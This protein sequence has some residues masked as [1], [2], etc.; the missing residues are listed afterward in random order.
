MKSRKIFLSILAMMLISVGSL[1]AQRQLLDRVVA[2]V[3]DEVINQSELDNVLHPIYEQ[4]EQEYEGEDLILRFNEVRRKLLN[5]LIEDRLVFQEAEEQKI[6]VEASELDARV[7]E[8]KTRF[9]DQ[10]TMEAAMKEQGLTLKDV[11]ERFRRQLMIK[12][13]HDREI[14]SKIIISPK[15]IEEYYRSHPEEFSHQARIKIRSITVKKNAVAR[16]K[17]LLDEEAKTQA[18]EIRRRVLAGEDFTGLAEQYSQD[19]Q[20][21]NGG[22]SDWIGRDEM[23]PVINDLIFSLK[24]G[25]ISPIIETPM[26]YHF[27][28]L[29]E[30]EEGHTRSLDEARNEIAGKI[31][32]QKSE[33]LFDEWMQEL[34]R[35]AYITIR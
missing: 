19:L 30:T 33:I 12:Q 5:Q 1:Y 22:L 24:V 32:Q 7:E 21:A 18:E 25:E 20:A 31:F 16:E 26:G 35:K 13:L 29:E 3:N 28:R 9:P 34:K 2:V 14:R 11:R 17:G 23:I 15:D 8:F 27:F 6:E 4:M 10:A